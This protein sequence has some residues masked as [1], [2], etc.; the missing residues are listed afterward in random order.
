MISSP[1]IGEPEH[2]SFWKYLVYHEIRA[3]AIYETDRGGYELTILAIFRPI[4]HAPSYPV[5]LLSISKWFTQF[6]FY[7][8]YKT[9]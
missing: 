8:K 3:R 1:L 7:Q 6:Y 4:N 9:Q 2:S 5:L